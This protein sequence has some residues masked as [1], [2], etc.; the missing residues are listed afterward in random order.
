MVAK[1]CAIVAVALTALTALA[2]C[3]GGG[4]P[5]S[6]ATPPTNPQDGPPA[7]YPD[8]NA[9]IPAEGQAEDVSSPTTVIVFFVSNNQTGSITITDSITSNNPRGTFE[10]PD[11]PGFYV[12]AKSPA[13]IINSQILR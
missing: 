13:Q 6:G 11:L 7:G 4:S 12:I 8:G 1:T 3:G 5:S 2:T 9:V 10:T